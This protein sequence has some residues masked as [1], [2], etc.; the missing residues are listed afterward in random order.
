[1]KMFCFNRKKKSNI[2]LEEGMYSHDIS[3]ISRIMHMDKEDVF[4][5]GKILKELQRHISRCSPRSKK[6]LRILKLKIL[7][8]MNVLND[9][10]KDVYI[11]SSIRGTLLNDLEHW[12]KY[13]K[14]RDRIHI[15]AKIINDHTTHR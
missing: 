10:H 12:H 9:N 2:R 8:Y 3:N 14:L 6:G 7:F 15:W 13:I 5:S 1:M 4:Y 11:Q